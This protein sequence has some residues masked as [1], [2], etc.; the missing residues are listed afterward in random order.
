[1]DSLHLSGG[2]INGAAW[3]G[4]TVWITNNDADPGTK[5]HQVDPNTMSVLTTY[6]YTYASGGFDGLTYAQGYL[7]PTYY[8]TASIWKIDPSDG[9]VLWQAPFP[10]SYCA[11][12]AFGGGYMWVGTNNATGK[13]YKVIFEE[14][15]I[16]K[17]KGGVPGVKLLGGDLI[18]PE[19]TW[20]LRAYSADGRLV[21]SRD[22]A[23]GQVKLPKLG[24]FILEVKGGGYRQVL[25]G[26]ITE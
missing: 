5:L 22:G 26:I 21:W 10:R 25:K 11:G 15:L 4:S 20:S 24:F 13:L 23:S 7:Y 14:P 12:L 9:S 8:P 6:N 17:E 2:Y 3:D 19:G 18:L 16:V 1:M